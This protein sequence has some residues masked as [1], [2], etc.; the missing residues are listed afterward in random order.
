M[1]V[2]FDNCAVGCGS[3]TNCVDGHSA[4]GCRSGADFVG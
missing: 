1:I 2:L 4:L 3:E